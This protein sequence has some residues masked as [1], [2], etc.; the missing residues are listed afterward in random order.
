MSARLH[1]RRTIAGLREI[2]EVQQIGGDV[3]ARPSV[4]LRAAQR[5]PSPRGA[6]A[7]EE[8]EDFFAEALALVASRWRRHTAATRRQGLGVAALMV[9]GGEGKGMKMAA[10]PIAAISATVTAP[11]RET[12]RSASASAPATSSRNARTSARTPSFDPPRADRVLVLH[13]VAMPAA[14]WCTTVRLATRGATAARASGIASL[15]ARAPWLPP[16]TSTRMGRSDAP[17][18]GV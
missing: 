1:A 13:V 14:A 3:T 4:G 5:R 12:T 9:V 17:R 8:R 18:R 7:F 6:L 11:A 10:R 15:M 2:R 16:M